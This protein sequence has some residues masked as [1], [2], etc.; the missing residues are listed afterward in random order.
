MPTGLSRGGRGGGGE[1]EGG[2]GGG[3]GEEEE[4]GEEGEVAEGGERQGVPMSNS[5]SLYAGGK[6]GGLS[7]HTLLTFKSLTQYKY[8]LLNILSC[9]IFRS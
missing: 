8:V 7:L 4:G 3:R 9:I 5:T 6:G 2:G 1:A